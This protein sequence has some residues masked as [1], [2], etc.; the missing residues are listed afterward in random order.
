MRKTQSEKLKASTPKGDHIT[1]VD[2]AAG[3][4][5]TSGGKWLPVDDLL[6]SG[7]LAE[8]SGE[9]YVLPE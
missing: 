3:I 6:K 5:Y 1:E 8:W 4:V 7:R 9:Y 2:E